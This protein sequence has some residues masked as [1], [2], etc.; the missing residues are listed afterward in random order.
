[1][2]L[3]IS[4][5]EHVALL[6]AMT[7]KQANAEDY[8]PGERSEVLLCLDHPSRTQH[9]GMTE[10]VYVYSG[11]VHG[12]CAGSYGGYNRWRSALAR[13]VGTTDWQ[14]WDDPRPGPFVELINFADNEGFIG[15]RTS[16]KL[17]AD[18]RQWDER[19]KVALDGWMYERYR[20][21]LKAFELASRD[22]AVKFH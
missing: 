19:A 5:F 4:S 16:A 3:D 8:D 10:G 11:K 13:M 1:M 7:V 12:F 15:P 22:G 2:G 17:A 6:R 21:W 9:D 18:F 20:L 14:A